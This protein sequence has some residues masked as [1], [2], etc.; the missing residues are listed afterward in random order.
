[1]NYKGRDKIVTA[2][3]IFQ[4]IAILANLVAIILLILKA[5]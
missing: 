4:V 1:M 2:T 5:M 3:M